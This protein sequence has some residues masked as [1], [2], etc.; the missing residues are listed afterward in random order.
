MIESIC[1]EKKL[2]KPFIRM[3]YSE[4][5]EKYGSDKPDWRYGLEMADITD[6]AKE[7][8]FRV[9]LNTIGNGGII[10]GFAI[11][12]QSNYSGSDMRRLEETAKEY[13]A[14]GMSHIRL[15]PDESGNLTDKGNYEEAVSQTLLTTGKAIISTG[16]ILALG[17]FVLYF[18]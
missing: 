12:Y 18:S 3:D 4:A 6:L 16:V 14:G 1:P 7:T 5:M 8:D 13:C 9:F 10:K 15:Q 17:F 11:P 2:I